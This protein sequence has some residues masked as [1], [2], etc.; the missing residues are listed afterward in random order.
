MFSVVRDLNQC[1]AN[2]TKKKE[3]HNSKPRNG[4]QQNCGIL[5]TNQP[6]SNNSPPPTKT[7]PTADVFPADA[8]MEFPFALSLNDD[9]NPWGDQSET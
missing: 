3:G 2:Y 5:P 9:G 4:S 6:S 8:R 1:Y 7:T